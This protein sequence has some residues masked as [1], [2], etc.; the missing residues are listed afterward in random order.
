MAFS[1]RPS[2]Q[3]KTQSGTF[4]FG[5]H[6][7]L[8]A[9]GSLIKVSLNWRIGSDSTNGRA[10]TTISTVRLSHWCKL[11]VLNLDCL[12]LLSWWFTTFEQKIL[13]ALRLVQ[14]RKS[15][16]YMIRPLRSFSAWSVDNKLSHHRS[17]RSVAH[18]NWLHDKR[19]QS[20][21][22]LLVW[23]L[24]LQMSFLAYL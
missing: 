1:G 4:G 9:I 10:S 5:S 2:S 13:L 20:F 24:C 23:M 18:S 22:R 16:S 3:A 11:I 14:K 21:V 17:E 19:L 6:R 12:S 8:L 15:R 7:S